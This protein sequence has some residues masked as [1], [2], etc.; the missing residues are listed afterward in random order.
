MPANERP[1]RLEQVADWLGVSVKTVRR[2]IDSGKLRSIK[3]GGLRVVPSDA[4]RA[5]WDNLNGRN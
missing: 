5:Y 1:L 3:L 4:F 2:Q